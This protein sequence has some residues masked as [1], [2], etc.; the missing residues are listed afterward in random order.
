MDSTAADIHA[1][2]GQT[3][4]TGIPVQDQTGEPPRPSEPLPNP[5]A[6]DNND[7]PPGGGADSPDHTI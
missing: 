5:S 7:S 4:H 2:A 6:P 1:E 3:I